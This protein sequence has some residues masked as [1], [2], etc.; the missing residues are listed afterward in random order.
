[1]S[2]TD[3][4]RRLREGKL[5]ASVIGCLMTG[6]ADKTLDLWRQMVGAEREEPDWE[7]IWPV[8]LGVASEALNLEWY[9]Y[10]TGHPLF[11]CG[12][13]VTHPRHEWACA[14][15]DGFDDA[16]VGPVDAKHVG[17]FEPRATVVARYLPQMTWQMDVSGAKRSALSIIEGARE[18]VTE[19]IEW[20]A[21]YSAEL[22]RRAA[23]F[24]ECVWSLTPPVEMPAVAAPVAAVREADLSANNLWC[25]EADAWLTNRNAAKRFTSSEKELKLLVEADVRR[26]HGAGIEITRDRANRLS[27]KELKP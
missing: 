22:W 9:A 17:G 26:A 14:T 15:L 7:R 21:E 5:T 10:K 27:I 13:V 6:D 2:L 16:L 20:H 3:E 11:R 12:E 25:V 23:V 24:M 18:P 1:M 4:Q 8:Q 19:I